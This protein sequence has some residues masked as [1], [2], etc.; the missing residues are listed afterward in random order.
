[1]AFSCE[2]LRGDIGPCLLRHVT[3]AASLAFPQL[4]EDWGARDIELGP[5]DHGSVRVFCSSQPD[6]FIC[7]TSVA[8]IQIL[9]AELGSKACCFLKTTTGMLLRSLSEN[10]KVPEESL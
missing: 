8:V 2:G 5:L 1:M 6:A 3:P 9:S 7:Q 4:P 10:N